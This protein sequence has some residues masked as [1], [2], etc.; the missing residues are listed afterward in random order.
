MTAFTNNLE[1]LIP[2]LLELPTLIHIITFKNRYNENK[3]LII[4]N[5]I[6]EKKKILT[7]VH[8]R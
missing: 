5:I 2:I 8:F 6:D 3:I 7:C 1:S 4:E